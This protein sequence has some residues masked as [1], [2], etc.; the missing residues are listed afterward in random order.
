MRPTLRQCGGAV[1][2]HWRLLL[3]SLFSGVLQFTE[4]ILALQEAI[5]YSLYH[6]AAQQCHTLDEATCTLNDF[7]DVCEYERSTASCRPSISVSGDAIN[8][9][10][11]WAYALFAISYGW[12]IGVAIVF[13]FIVVRFVVKYL[14]S[15][16]RQSMCTHDMLDEHKIHQRWSCL[17]LSSTSRLYFGLC[18]CCLH[19]E[20]EFDV[21]AA[22]DSAFAYE[23]LTGM[24]VQGPMFAVSLLLNRAIGK[25]EGP[26]WQLLLVTVLSGVCLTSAIHDFATAEKGAFRRG[27]VNA[28]PV[29]DRCWCGKHAASEESQPLIASADLSHE[30]VVQQ[31]AQQDR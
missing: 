30:V 1:T 20:S 10:N 22:E 18:V 29:L 24:F 26:H 31:P 5:Q 4:G 9:Y 19:H 11:D 16:A 15:S 12:M 8:F 7:E 21:V 23:V 13:T 6:D 3:W 2:R 17:A 28:V 14:M 27:L 25:A